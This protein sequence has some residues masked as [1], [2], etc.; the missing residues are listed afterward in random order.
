[1]ENEKDRAFDFLNRT[2]EGIAKMFGTSCETLIH[3]MTKPGHPI[4][5][6]YNG[7]VSGRSIGSTADIY[8]LYEGTNEVFFTDR[9]YVD[10]LVI[11]SAG[12]HVKSSTF[13]YIGEEYHYAMGI[14]FDYS[15]ILSASNLLVELSHAG[16]DLQS[17][18]KSD[19]VT[20]IKDLFDACMT[21]I[22]VSIDRMKKADRYRLVALLHQK[23]AFSYQKSVLYVAEKLNVSRYTIYKY[24][25]EI[26]ENKS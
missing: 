22:G 25:N 14:N 6:I 18:I 17:A 4:L 16:S 2:I 11:T 12:R 9:D 7:H 24:L 26:K 3:D 20:Y 1:M 23:K 13:N 5:A 19:E 8:G 10:H 21:S 15:S